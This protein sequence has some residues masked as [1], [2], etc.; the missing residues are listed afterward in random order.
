MR[1]RVLFSPPA[2]RDFGRNPNTNRSPVIVISS[3]GLRFPSKALMKSPDGFPVSAPSILSHQA[4]PCGSL[5]TVMSQGPSK[6]DSAD[7]DETVVIV[8]QR[9]AAALKQNVRFMI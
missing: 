2:K 6:P 7:C 9:R 5:G 8:K 1:W 3:M 4:R